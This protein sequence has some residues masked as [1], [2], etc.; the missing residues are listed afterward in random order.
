MAI[1]FVQ[2]GT[3]AATGGGALVM[4]VGSSTTLGDTLLAAICWDG[5]DNATVPS[6]PTDT[7]GNT[8]SLIESFV[9]TTGT[10]GNLTSIA[11]Y[12]APIT[13]SGTPTATISMT[14]RGG[15][16]L[17]EYGGTSQ[18]VDQT[19]NGQATTGTSV[20]TGT[21]GSTSTA[22][23]LIFL[24]GASLAGG[25]TVPY[26]ASGYT[27]RV[28]GATA[29]AGGLTIFDQIVSSTGTFGATVTAMPSGGFNAALIITIPAAGGG[30]VT[31]RPVF[32]IL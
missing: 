23:E 4:P 10:T 8:Y 12:A 27:A 20:I 22:H 18:T 29:I 11:V 5:N 25:S 26:A 31:V 30:P 21:T 28:S 17:L 6:V 7:S 9:N 3:V 15:G 14:Q 1:S 32:L 24:V 2:A 13:S 16:V 19:T